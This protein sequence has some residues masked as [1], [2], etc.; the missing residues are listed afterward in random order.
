MDWRR[1]DFDWNHLRAFLVTADEG[2]FSAASQA[3]GIAQPTVGRQIAALEEKLGVAL[4]ERAGR[5]LALTPT[6]LEL[7]EHVRTMSDAAFRVARVA[8]GQALSLDGPIC[9]TASEIV[10]TYLL[11]PLVAELRARHSGIEVEIVASNAPQD[12]R[13]READIAIRS[14]RPTEPDLVARKV[15]DSEAYLYAAPTYL[16][17]LGTPLT[18]DAL[19]RATFIGFDHTDT[20]RKGLSV[21]GLSL[22]PESFPLVSQSQHV[23]WALVREGAGIGIMIAEVGD[24]EP[25]VCRVLAD[26]PAIPVPMWIVT[27]RE[28]RTSRRVRVVAEFLAE[29]LSPG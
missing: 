19:S 24:A 22:P 1:V 9:L 14:F 20:F 28:V 10:A 11:P 21:L 15:R 6:G 18:R 7:V 29:R 16:R 17:K 3:L 4:F 12:L 23:Q 25:G 8:A 13:R 26:L 2:S 5:G 27:H